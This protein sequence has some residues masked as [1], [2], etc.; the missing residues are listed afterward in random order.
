LAEFLNHPSRGIFLHQPNR[1]P[2]SRGFLYLKRNC[3]VCEATR[4]D[5]RQSAKGTIHCRSGQSDHNGWHHVGTDRQGFGLYSQTIRPDWEPPSPKVIPIAKALSPSLAIPVIDQAYRRI[6]HHT[7]RLT[8]R[9]RID[10]SKRGL[11]IEQ[12][13]RLQADKTLFGWSPG[14]SIPNL[15]PI[16]GLN[17]YGKLQKFNGYAI[18]LQNPAGEILGVQIKL[19]EPQRSELERKYTWTSGVATAHIQ[20]EMPLGYCNFTGERTG[21]VYLA[22]GALKS[23]LT[24]MLHNIEVIGSP[25][26]GWAGSPRLFKEYLESIGASVIRLLP[27]AGMLDAPHRTVHA[28]YRRVVMLLRDWGYVVEVGWWGQ[29]QYKDPD[30]DELRPQEWSRVEWISWEVYDQFQADQCD[31]NAWLTQKRNLERHKW[32]ERHR[33]S[34]DTVLHQAPFLQVDWV[35]LLGDLNQYFNW[36]QIRLKTDLLAIRSPMGTGK[37]TNLV[38]LC[39]QTDLGMTLLGTKNSL[40]LAAAE[41]LPGF[42]HLQSDQSFALLRDPQ[43]RHSLCLESLHHI[44][45][46]DCRGKIILLDEA[47]Q[48]RK[49]L[50]FSRTLSPAKRR[51]CEQKLHEMFQGCAGLILLSAELD[52]ATVDFF[53]QLAGDRVAQIHRIDNAI[54]IQKWDIELLETQTADGKRTINN[55]TPEVSLILRT[56]DALKAVGSGRRAIAIASDNQNLLERIDELL[57]DQSYRTFRLDSK[58]TDDRDAFLKSP[59]E[60]LARNRID[61]LLYSPSAESGLDISIQNYFYKTFVLYHGVVDIDG[62]LQMAGRIRD[63]DQYLF[64][65]REFAKT[66]EDSLS[67]T[68]AKQLKRSIVGYM[69]EDVKLSELDEDIAQ[70]LMDQFA[71]QNDHYWI[72][73]ATAQMALWN[74]EKFNLWDNLRLAL[75][76]QG[77]EIAVCTPETD[78]GLKTQLQGYGAAIIKNEA[79]QTFTAPDIPLNQAINNLSKFTLSPEDRYAAEKALLKAQLPGIEHTEAW[80]PGLIEYLL[81]DRG[82]V[83]RLERLYLLQNLAVVQHKARTQWTEW[84]Q[85]ELPFMTD[86]RSDLALLT[87]IDDMQLLDLVGEEVTNESPAVLARYK[88]GKLAVFKTR[89]QRSPGKPDRAIAYVGRLARMVGLESTCKRVRRYKGDLNPD[90]RYT[91]SLPTHPYDLAILGCIERRYT[92]ISYSSEIEPES[93]AERV[94][95]PDPLTPIYLNKTAISGSDFQEQVGQTFEV[96]NA[97][98]RIIGIRDY[99]GAVCFVLE[100]QG[101]RYLPVFVPCDRLEEWRR[102]LSGAD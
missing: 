52:D 22:E 33:Y 91:Y 53:R 101:Y 50:M 69:A 96:G 74:Y 9:H 24:A 76:H 45:A 30:C 88:K 47:P 17:A 35:E 43:G 44:K 37:T 61:V 92:K 90:R 100:Y 6:A 20:G 83:R 98:Y 79:Y 15:Q 94:I 62:I 57:L 51:A 23:I 54:T 29:S 93:Y 87:A 97:E 48:I 95:E 49:H 7:G 64:A 55:R 42:T 81:K 4:T 38:N 59:D 36:P 78:P 16:A 73:H 86:I 26:A 34:A 2:L 32:L 5:C 65:A 72:R 84:S 3:P 99:L 13:D 8:H 58:T 80:Q 12:I 11:T 18:A 56:L 31:D 60:W 21:I 40:M 10:L 63:C 27:D 25:S 28:Q 14:I 39:D 70:N 85:G 75:E 102:S 1:I 82:Q 46:S 77:H 41:K 67:S 68:S 71:D 66:D 89:L 19:D